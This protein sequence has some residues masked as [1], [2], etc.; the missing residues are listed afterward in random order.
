M[1]VKLGDKNLQTSYIKNMLAH[2]P[3]PLYEPLEDGG[4]VLSGHSYIYKGKIV[5]AVSTQS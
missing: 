1:P 2:F 3:L 5:K 4:L